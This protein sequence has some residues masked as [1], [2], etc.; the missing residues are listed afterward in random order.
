MPADPVGCKLLGTITNC[1]HVHMHLCTLRPWGGA[2]LPV[3]YDP[4]YTHCLYT[5]TKA[6]SLQ[7]P[8]QLRQ[9]T[10]RLLAGKPLVQML[11]WLRV[12]LLAS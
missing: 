8:Q 5:A 6:V 3:A 7:L 2:W 4:L 10:E 1:L 12:A 9:A 11:C